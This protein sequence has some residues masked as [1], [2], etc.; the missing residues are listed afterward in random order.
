VLSWLDERAR[1]AARRPLRAWSVVLAL[2]LALAGC[3]IAIGRFIIGDQAELFRELA[4][5]TF[6]SFAELVFTAA[7]ARAVHLRTA[8]GSGWRRLD[9]FWALS[10]AFFAVFAF[11]EI[12]QTSQFLGTFLDET[13]ELEAGAFHD[14]GAIVL[15][16]L[17]GICALVLLRRVLVLRHHPLAFVLLAAG[18]GFGAG[19]QMLDSFAEATRWEFVAEETLKLTAEAFFIGGFLVAL[20][21]VLTRTPR[22]HA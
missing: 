21:D 9:N 19:S 13:L 20:R 6:L 11:D 1:A 16:V 22:P 2:N 12:T 15:T 14:I 7:V 18:A 4:P 10:A 3:F 8:T 17:F 5:G